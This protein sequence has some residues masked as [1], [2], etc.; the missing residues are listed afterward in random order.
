[1][2]LRVLLVLMP[3]TS[4]IPRGMEEFVA[5]CKVWR[6]ELADT[7]KVTDFGWVKAAVMS[8]IAMIDGFLAAWETYLE[9]D[10]SFNRGRKD[11][12]RDEAKRGI[13]DFANK[14]VR[15][16][17]LMTEPDKNRLGVY[18]RR[19]P[20]PVPVP[21]TVPVLM[22]R[23]GNPREV[24]V[25][26]KDRESANRGKPK[27]VHAIKIRWGLLDHA[28]LNVKELVN[29][30]LDTRSPCRLVFEEQDRGKWLYLAGCWQIEREGEEGEYGEIVKVLV[31]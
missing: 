12:L 27:G 28:P 26:Y 23:A 20:H 24:V 16:N 22:P 21:L 3:G 5:F 25:P 19:P 30:T 4:W 18:T 6:A 7:E 17:D 10:S 14:F 11:L 2:D 31:P 1:M 8:L 13:E 15:F 29:A 9:D